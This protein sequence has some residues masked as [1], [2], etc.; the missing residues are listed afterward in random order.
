MSCI[1]V[2]LITGYLGAGKTSLLNHLLALPRIREQNPALIINEFGDFGIDGALIASGDY[3]LFELNKGS[4]F[5]ICTKT[6]FLK[7]LRTIAENV[8][9][10]LVII[11]AKGV[12]E[13]AD[14]EQIIS[15]PD[16]RD[17]FEIKANLCLVD[18]AHFLKVLPMLKA[19]RE[20]A[21]RADALIVNKTD[22]A[23]EGELDN[24]RK[25]LSDLNPTA[26]IICTTHGQIK[27]TLLDSLQHRHCAA[28]LSTAPPADVFALSVKYTYPV[29]RQR[30]FSVI[31]QFRPHILRMKGTVHFDDGMQYI[32][33][34]GSELLERNQASQ[35]CSSALVVIGWNISRNEMLRAFSDIQDD[36]LPQ[37]QGIDIQ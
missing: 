23:A 19:A 24:I 11:E 4:L 16:L 1:P 9:T 21:L 28:S 33:I 34:A 26:P 15:E 6:D 10:G 27:A 18:A 12:A 30:F 5:C 7:T 29:D 32:E 2:I 35:S 14:L 36:T 20:Q 22:L 17:R 8:Q 25:V 31:Q 3:P 37:L 13:P